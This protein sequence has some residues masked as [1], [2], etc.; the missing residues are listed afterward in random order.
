MFEEGV[1]IVDIETV[2]SKHNLGC[3]IEY[4]SSKFSL[5]LFLSFAARNAN[6]GNET[7]ELS[8]GNCDKLA[9]YC[10]CI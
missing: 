3:V 7:T 5:L 8:F 6:S 2:T 10:P 1:G 9:I 4:I